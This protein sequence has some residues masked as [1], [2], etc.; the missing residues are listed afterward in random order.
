MAAAKQHLRAAL[1]VAARHPAPSLPRSSANRDNM[2]I[3]TSNA[4]SC[5]NV[6]G[7]TGE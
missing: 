4:T 7:D 5:D 3:C 2:L 6:G 1:R